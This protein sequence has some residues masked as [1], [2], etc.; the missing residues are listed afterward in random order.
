[1][2]IT[3]YPFSLKFLFAPILDAYFL[4]KFGKRKSYIVPANYITAILLFWLSYTIDT[5]IEE[6]NISLLIF[7]IFAIN[8]CMAF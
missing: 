4:P 2:S 5:F 7:I 6:A 8:V 1:M 3:S